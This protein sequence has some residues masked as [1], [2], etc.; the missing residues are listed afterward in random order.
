MPLMIPSSSSGNS[1][2]RPSSSASL[3]PPSSA[4][5]RPGSS[6]SQRP[7]SALN[8]RPPSSASMRPSSR[9]SQRAKSRSRLTPI[10]QTLVTQITGMDNSTQHLENFNTAVEFAVQN[11]EAT[12]LVNLKGS[13]GVDMSTMDKQI[14]G[15]VV[16]EHGYPLLPPMHIQA[17][18][19]GQNPAS[20]II[21]PGFGDCLSS[22]QD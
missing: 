17:C 6:A 11:L 15:C 8:V 7:S 2:G 20:G 16:Y 22:A 13:V 21:G 10:C 5:R 4:S 18:R 9:L 1:H 14:R 3:R 12:S 19:K